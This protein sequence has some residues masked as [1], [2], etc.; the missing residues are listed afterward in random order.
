MGWSVV[1]SP[2]RPGPDGVGCRVRC[3]YRARTAPLRSPTSLEIEELDIQY[4]YCQ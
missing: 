1:P 2:F 4:S 3:G